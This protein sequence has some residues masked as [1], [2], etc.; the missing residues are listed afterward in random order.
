MKLRYQLQL[1]VSDY[2]I[3]NNIQR[4]NGIFNPVTAGL[5]KYFVDRQN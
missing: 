4:Y 5:F 1:V 3:N 2:Y